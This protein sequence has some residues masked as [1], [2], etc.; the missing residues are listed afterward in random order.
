MDVRSDRLSVLANRGCAVPLK[1]NFNNVPQVTN[2]PVNV[3]AYT[4]SGSSSR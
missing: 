4:K 1:V 3:N 2:P